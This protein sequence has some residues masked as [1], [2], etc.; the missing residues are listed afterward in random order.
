MGDSNADNLKNLHI[1]DNTAK[2]QKKV[3]GYFN[4]LFLFVIKLYIQIKV[5][6]LLMKNFCIIY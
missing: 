2:K 5:I 1:K 4:Y 6:I 3:K